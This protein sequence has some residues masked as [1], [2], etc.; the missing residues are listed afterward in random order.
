MLYSYTDLDG[1]F[2]TTHLM[3]INNYVYTL[4]AIKK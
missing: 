2:I 4:L 3:T 1:R